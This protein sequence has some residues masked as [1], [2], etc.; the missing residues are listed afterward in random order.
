MRD[1]ESLLN[2]LVNIDRTSLIAILSSEAEAAQRLVNSARQRTAA[3]RAKRNEAIKRAARIDRILLFF[4]NG[5]VVPEISE[6]DVMLCKS[7]E[8]RLRVRGDCQPNRQRIGKHDRHGEC[9]RGF[10]HRWRRTGQFPLHQ[11]CGFGS[12]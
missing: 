3:Q 9:E 4:Q 5:D 12:G 6:H 1:L 8:D 10:D 7:L 11:H 2:S